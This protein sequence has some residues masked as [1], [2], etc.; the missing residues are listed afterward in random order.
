MAGSIELQWSVDALADLN[1][2][3]AFLHEQSPELAAIVADAI[4]ARTQI[5]TLVAAGARPTEC[6]PRGPSSFTG[7]LSTT[8]AT[9]QTRSP[10]GEFLHK[11]DAL[12]RVTVG[13]SVASSCVGWGRSPFP[14]TSDVL[15]PPPRT[16]L[17]AK[18]AFAAVVKRR[19]PVGVYT[20]ADHFELAPDLGTG[21]MVEQKHLAGF[22][23][24]H[25]VDLEPELV[26]VNHDRGRSR[27]RSR[28][29][30]IPR[31]YER[32]VDEVDHRRD[33]S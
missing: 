23:P 3:G 7:C 5:L 13:E 2:F 10:V 18:R 15:F 11:V 9:S 30:V 26:V 1:R 31:I 22:R 16:L 29:H 25:Q 28:V 4:V 33:V 32:A 6:S 27:D 14:A 20:C 17:A 19:V 21:D 8:P 24:R 12:R